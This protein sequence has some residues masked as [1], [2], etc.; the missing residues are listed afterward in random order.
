VLSTLNHFEDEY[1]AHLLDQICPA[2][3]CKQF[4]TFAINASLCQGCGLC[5]NDCPSGA[6]SGERKQ[7][8]II[9]PEVCSRCGSCVDT[10][11]FGAISGQ[12]VKMVLAG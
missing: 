9:D 7:A 12:S 2:G 6:I 3:Q 8:H 11:A 4:L 1:M 10:C 5:K